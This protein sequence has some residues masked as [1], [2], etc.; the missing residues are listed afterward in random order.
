MLA[1]L[2]GSA[3][4]APWLAKP[5]ELASAGV[6]LGQNY[7]MPVVQHDEARALTLQRYAIVKKS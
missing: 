2:P 3:L 6:E 1:G 7:P 5:M 4:H